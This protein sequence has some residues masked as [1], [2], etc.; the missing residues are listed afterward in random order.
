MYSITENNFH[1]GFEFLVLCSGCNMDVHSCIISGIPD[2]TVLNRT[3][4]ISE[5]LSNP[6]SLRTGAGFISTCSYK[7]EFMSPKLAFY[8]IMRTK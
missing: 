1:D 5:F 6:A 4:R 3:L 2:K 7:Y 8:H